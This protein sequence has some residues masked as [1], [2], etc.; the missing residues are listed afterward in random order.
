MKSCQKCGSVVKEWDVVC[1]VCGTTLMTL[2]QPKNSEKVKGHLPG[3]ED[4]QPYPK[5]EE[6]AA[7]NAADSRQ[8]REGEFD[9]R[10]VRAA[11]K[12]DA[13]RGMRPNPKAVKALEQV[14][15]LDNE[16]PGP[17][18]GAQASAEAVEEAVE[19]IEEVEAIEEDDETGVPDNAQRVKTK[20]VKQAAGAQGLQR[21]AL[22]QR[23]GTEEINVGDI[24]RPEKTDEI[25]L[26]DILPPEKTDQIAVSDIIRPEGT[27]EVKISDIIAPDD[28]PPTGQIVVEGKKRQGERPGEAPPAKHPS[29]APPPPRPAP[30]PQAAPPGQSGPP[31]PAVLPPMEPQPPQTAPRPQAPAIQAAR[32]PASPLPA[33]ALPIKAGPGPLA[34]PPQKATI[35][36]KAAPLPSVPDI[37][38]SPPPKID[39]VKL[40]APPLQAAPL[41][42]VSRPVQAQTPQAPQQ[43]AGGRPQQPPMPQAVEPPERER[44]HTD[45]TGGH[46][47][48]P[49]TLKRIMQQAQAA[50]MSRS[51]KDKPGST[52]I[53]LP[54]AILLVAMGTLSIIGLAIIAYLLIKI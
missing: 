40:A 31:P 41:Q 30:L 53:S 50:A 10:L 38:S 24:L 46:Q 21:G 8:D 22:S 43:P 14:S 19:E 11:I 36:P 35:P 23:E 49:E 29:Q 28:E 26:S 15:F 9:Q 4:F 47:Y 52:H 32:P 48:D 12:S 1:P 39:L 20:D 33:L 6:S 13:E 54:L 37:T 34:A 17:R 44:Q 3:W 7:D 42:Q 18:K 16:M 45:P 5:T 27:E 25:A 2:S 51:A